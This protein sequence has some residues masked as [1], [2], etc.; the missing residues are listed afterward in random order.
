[1]TDVRDSPSRARLLA[2]HHTLTPH[3]TLL[4]GRSGPAHLVDEVIH[5][6]EVMRV[7]ARG[8][9]VEHP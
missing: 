2:P 7:G 4:G 8:D 1:M 5:A 3:H 6:R 9:G